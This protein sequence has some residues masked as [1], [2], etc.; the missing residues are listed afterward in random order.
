MLPRQQREK[1]GIARWSRR[2]SGSSTM[3]K[4]SV[5]GSWVRW[6]ASGGRIRWASS[7]RRRRRSRRDRAQLLIETTAVR[8]PLTLLARDEDEERSREERRQEEMG[9]E[10]REIG[11]FYNLFS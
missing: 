3:S 8:H 1:A 9:S 4:R 2:V 5:W 6:A 10:R 11:T 7:R